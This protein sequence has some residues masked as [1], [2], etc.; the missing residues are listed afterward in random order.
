MRSVSKAFLQPLEPYLSEFLLRSGL[1]M[2]D[3]ENKKLG[4]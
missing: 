2:A 1:T 3:I 4:W